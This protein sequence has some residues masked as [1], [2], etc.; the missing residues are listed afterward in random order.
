MTT[1]P[2]IP[3]V[4]FTETWKCDDQHLPC[5]PRRTFPTL[6][7]GNQ[8]IEAYINPDGTPVYYIGDLEL[9]R[10]EARNLLSE[11]EALVQAEVPNLEEKTDHSHYRGRNGLV[12]HAVGGRAVTSCSPV[13]GS[14]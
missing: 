2:Q 9:S 8:P 3:F 5:T 6:R 11:I 1:N 12:P 13:Y 14:V 7:E 4:A 10:E